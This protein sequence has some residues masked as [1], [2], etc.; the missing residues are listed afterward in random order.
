[1]DGFPSAV[2]VAFEISTYDGFSP[3]DLIAMLGELALVS[4][5]TNKVF[6]ADVWI[7]PL[8]ETVLYGSY[9]PGMNMHLPYLEH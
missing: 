2:N 3:L 8:F 1:M 9:F 7:D 5:T 4:F 6:G